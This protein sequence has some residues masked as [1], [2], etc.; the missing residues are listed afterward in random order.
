MQLLVHG[1]WTTLL[2]LSY[3]LVIIDHTSEI[4][5]WTGNIWNELILEPTG[6]SM[7]FEPTTLRNLLG[8]SN[9]WVTGVM[10]LWAKLPV[11]IWL[12]S[13]VMQLESK[14]HISPF[15]VTESPV[16]Q[17]LE[18]PNGLRRGVGSNPIWGWV[19]SE[20]PVGSTVNWFHI[21]HPSHI[22]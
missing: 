9:H 15:L 11:V 21:Y 7:G 6:N 8:C 12:C 10:Q 20:F 22:C 5:L 14:T 3:Y 1:F 2:S 17:W 4:V 13:C 16:A 18:H 19:F